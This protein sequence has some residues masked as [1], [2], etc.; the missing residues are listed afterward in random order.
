MTQRTIA[1]EERLPLLQTIRLSLQLLFARF[2][3]AVLVPSL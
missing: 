1:P 3:S 2:G